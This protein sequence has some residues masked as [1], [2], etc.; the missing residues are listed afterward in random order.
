MSGFVATLAYDIIFLMNPD[1][2]VLLQKTHDLSEENNRILHS[3]R[4]SNRLSSVFR[5]IYWVFIIVA[6]LGAYQLLQPYMDLAS[7][8]YSS[9]QRDINGVKTATTKITDPI[10]NLIN[11]VK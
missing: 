1:E 6:A 2:K 11:K 5:V 10:N 4:R 9:L 7:K 8:A 3:L